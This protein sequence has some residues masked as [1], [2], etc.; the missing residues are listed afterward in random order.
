MRSFLSQKEVDNLYTILNITLENG[1]SWKHDNEAE[2]FSDY[3]K[4]HIGSDYGLVYSNYKIYVNFHSFPSRYTIIS[5]EAPS[6]DKIEAIFSVFE[7]H[8]HDCQLP[9]LPQ[10]EKT[11]SQPIVFI[12]HGGSSQWKELKDHLHEKHGFAVEAYEV[13]ARAGHA[14][15]DILEHMLSKSSIAF[16]VMTGEDKDEH[17]NPRARQNVIHELG[18]F[19]GHLGFAR[20]VVILE[21]G[22]DEFSNIH[23]IQ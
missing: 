7:K 15:R 12:G 23:G 18:L 6:R 5:I 19:Q 20:A 4:I 3:R 11:E 8:A 22:T 21:E 16:L 10:P 1:D 14:I 17:G 9:P 2:F 13:G